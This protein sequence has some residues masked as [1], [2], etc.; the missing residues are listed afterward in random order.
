M[1]SKAATFWGG[2]LTSG[3]YTLGDEAFA[4]MSVGGGVIAEMRLANDA[5]TALGAG[6]VL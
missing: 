6:G 5:I 2:S 4:A 1:R 3:R